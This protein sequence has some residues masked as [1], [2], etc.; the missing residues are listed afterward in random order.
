M[1]ISISKWGLNSGDSWGSSFKGYCIN[2]MQRPLDCAL[3]NVCLQNSRTGAQF[4]AQH[5]IRI[6]FCF[7]DTIM[8]AQSCRQA[9]KMCDFVLALFKSLGFLINLVVRSC[10]SPSFH[11][12]WP[13]LGHSWSLNGLEHWKSPGAAPLSSEVALCKVTPLL[14]CATF[15]EKDKFPCFCSATWKA[16]HTW[17]SVLFFWDLS[18]FW[19]FQKVH[20]VLRCATQ[21]YL[22]PTWWVDLPQFANSLSHPVQLLGSYLGNGLKFCMGVICQSFRAEHIY[23]KS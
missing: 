22:E 20:P 10:S 1:P 23:S 16:D 9:V 15:P 2:F 19:P 4:C 8:I 7:D 18:C 3:H 21:T 13:S 5:N 6:V 14:W 17:N 11:F 12:S